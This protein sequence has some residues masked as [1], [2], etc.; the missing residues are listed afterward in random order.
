M[1]FG[2]NF[3]EAMASFLL[4]GILSIIVLEEDFLG[5]STQ[6][7]W[8]DITV[9]QTLALEAV[10]VVNIALIFYG[11]FLDTSHVS[12]IKKESE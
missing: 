5:P 8:I 1:Y 10:F 6:F 4:W 12:S 9:L 11:A 3:F 7:T 2:K